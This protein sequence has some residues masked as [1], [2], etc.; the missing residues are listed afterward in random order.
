MAA[1][2]T[3]APRCSYCGCELAA[4]IEA[5]R[6]HRS[7]CPRCP[8]CKGWRLLPLALADGATCRNALHGHT[9]AAVNRGRGSSRPA[10]RPEL[11]ALEAL[12]TSRPPGPPPA[13]P[14]FPDAVAGAGTFPS[15]TTA[16]EAASPAAPPAPPERQSP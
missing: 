6:E 12:F 8:D 9:D 13:G 4:G 11:R 10:A 5:V 2:D 16:S 14:S 1:T 15:S 7:T 3:R